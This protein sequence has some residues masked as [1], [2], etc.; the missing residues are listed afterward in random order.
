MEHNLAIG[1]RSS[2]PPGPSPPLPVLRREGFREGAAEGS[3]GRMMGPCP[4]AL[5]HDAVSNKQYSP[6]SYRASPSPSA[7]TYCFDGNLPKNSV[8][9]YLLVYLYFIGWFIPYIYL[10]DAKG[11]SPAL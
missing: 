5:L 6:H 8:V 4:P 3:T 9:F 1:P 10:T 7:T 11:Y 2:M